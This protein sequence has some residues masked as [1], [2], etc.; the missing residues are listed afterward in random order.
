MNIE[1]VKAI[2]PGNYDI[3]CDEILDFM[4][5]S[6]RD[7]DG[8]IEA[9]SLAYRYGFMRGQ[10]KVK[11]DMR[12]KKKSASAATETQEEPRLSNQHDYY[13]TARPKMSTERISTI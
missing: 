5:M 11:N 9:I 7:A 12:R 13:T 4:N 6:V 3:M 1:K 8:L 2:N 10:N